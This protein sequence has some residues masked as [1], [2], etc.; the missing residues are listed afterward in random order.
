MCR[1]VVGTVAH[2]QCI[3]SESTGLSVNA[4]LMMVTRCDTPVTSFSKDFRQDALS[5]SPVEFA[6]ENLFPGS[7]VEF[8]FGDGDDDFA[9][10]DLALE[11]R[12]GVV[13]AGPVV[14]ILGDEIGRAS[15][16]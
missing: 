2:R 10:H 9:A 11:M 16:R 14:G 6:V 1:I 4:D 13:F 15:C 8:A 3:R 5:A 7:E 12:V